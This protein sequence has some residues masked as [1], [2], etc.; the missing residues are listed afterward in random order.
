MEQ[1]P[2]TLTR[3]VA[4]GRKLRRRTGAY[5]AYLART[6]GF[7]FQATLQVSKA[8]MVE[9]AVRDLGYANAGIIHMQWAS[10]YRYIAL[11]CIPSALSRSWYPTAAVQTSTSYH[12]S[13]SGLLGEILDTPTPRGVQSPNKG[14]HASSRALVSGCWRVV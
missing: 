8:L 10:R 6:G 14:V 1:W 2:Q 9:S 11:Q 12:P 4:N 13:S 3:V 7:A 5:L